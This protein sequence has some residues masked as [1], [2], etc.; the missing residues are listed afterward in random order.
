LTGDDGCSDEKGEGVSG[1]QYDS[2]GTGGVHDTIGLSEIDVMCGSGKVARR[3]VGGR[4][5]RHEAGWMVRVTDAGRD[6]I[7]QE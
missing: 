4:G 7:M 3:G 2:T 5:A 1:I 6:R